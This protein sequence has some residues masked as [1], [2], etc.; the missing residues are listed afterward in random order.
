[1]FAANEMPLDLGL[2]GDHH[3]VMSTSSLPGLTDVCVRGSAARYAFDLADRSASGWVVPLGASG[4]LGDPHHHDQLP[5]WLRGALAPADGEATRED[6][7]FT[8][9]VDGVGTAT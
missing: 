5:L 4:V 9:S 2:S 6:R 1:V 8:T 7:S 3:C